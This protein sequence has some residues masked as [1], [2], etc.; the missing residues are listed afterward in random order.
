MLGW[1]RG[2]VKAC[3]GLCR[4]TAKCSLPHHR[5]G[6]DLRPGPA[7]TRC[8]A[9]P[10]EGRASAQ[11]WHGPVRV[12]LRARSRQNSKS[13]RRPRRTE[14]CKQSSPRFH[15]CVDRKYRRIVVG[16]CPRVLQPMSELSDWRSNWCRQRK[17][18]PARAE[19]GSGSR[20]RRLSQM[21]TFGI[22]FNRTLAHL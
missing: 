22:D 7:R 21:P 12:R 2:E 20:N 4:A 5:T 18:R 13:H 8:A 17:K 3:R 6:F 15:R 11:A 16:A 14:G 10:C 19:R 1:A 9:L